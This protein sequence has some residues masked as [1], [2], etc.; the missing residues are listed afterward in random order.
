MPG[1]YDQGA[2][3][4]RRYGRGSAIRTMPKTRVVSFDYAQL[5]C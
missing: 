5:V 1:C 4:I 2:M 3:A